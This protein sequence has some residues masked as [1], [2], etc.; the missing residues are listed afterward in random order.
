VHVESL[1]FTLLK[2][3]GGVV[4]SMTRDRWDDFS[5]DVGGHGH[6]P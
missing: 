4:G 2:Q 1:A 3:A 6:T 5:G